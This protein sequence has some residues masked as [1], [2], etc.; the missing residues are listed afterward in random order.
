[1]A[2]FFWDGHGIIL[3]DY[4]Q[5]GKPINAAYYA[6]LL[7]KLK[8]E[9]AEKRPHSQK[10]FLFQQDN[11]PSDTSVVAMEKIH[12]LWF[13]LLDHPPYSLDLAQSDSFLFS[14]PKIAFGEQRFSTK[15]EVITFVNNYFAEKNDEFYLSGLQRL[16]RRWEK[17]EELQVD[18]VEKLKKKKF[19]RNVLYLCR[20]GNF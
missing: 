12:E 13:E 18:Y 17:C 8:A 20:V 1:M 16:E 7:D 19:R 14:H 5:K 11:A 6:S 15:E 2:T 9:L 4:L 10:K 3:I